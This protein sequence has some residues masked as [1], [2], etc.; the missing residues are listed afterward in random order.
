MINYTILWHISNENI[1]D[2]YNE[3]VLIEIEFLIPRIVEHDDHSRTVLVE[4]RCL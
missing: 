4:F 3:Y 1:H 2:E